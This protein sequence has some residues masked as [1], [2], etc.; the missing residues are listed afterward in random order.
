MG[1]YVLRL[2]LFGVVSFFVVIC[3]GGTFVGWR[4]IYQIAPQPYSPFLW[5]IFL[6]PM[7]PFSK[8]GGA[9]WPRLPKKGLLRL[10]GG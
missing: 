2:N 4:G 3:W 7:L 8:H 5:G 6:G 9:P 1:C 10:A